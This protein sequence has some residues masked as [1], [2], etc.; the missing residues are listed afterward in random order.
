MSKVKARPV[1][2][3]DRDLPKLTPVVVEDGYLTDTERWGGPDAVG[4]VYAL[5]WPQLAPGYVQS[6]VPRIV[7]T[8]IVLGH[9]NYL[10]AVRMHQLTQ[11]TLEDPV[12]YSTV[13]TAQRDKIFEL[14]VGAV[15][16]YFAL[17]GEYVQDD[18]DEEDTWW[19]D[20]D[21]FARLAW[22]EGRT[23]AAH[24]EAHAVTRSSEL[25]GRQLQ[26]RYPEV[27]A[28]RRAWRETLR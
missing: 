21:Q 12:I 8:R 1:R 20:W 19:V 3:R 9:A 24:L 17:L 28:A 7:E 25:W 10:R 5:V 11:V 22:W 6:L 2:V 27:A 26:K 13:E 16:A 18:G 4:N 23:G 15:K 14:A